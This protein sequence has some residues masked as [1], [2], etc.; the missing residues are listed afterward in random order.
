M[1]ETDSSN[2]PSLIHINTDTESSNTDTESSNTDTLSSRISIL[3][4]FESVN[5]SSDL[6]SL[7]SRISI[8]TNSDDHSALSDHSDVQSSLSRFTVHT[9][10]S[11]TS[12]ST[13]EE[14]YH[15]PTGEDSESVSLLHLSSMSSPSISE[16]DLFR[17]A[18]RAGPHYESSEEESCSHNSSEP[19]VCTICLGSD[20]D[21]FI[22]TVCGHTFHYYCLRRACF[23]QERCPNCRQNF[24]DY[25][26]HRHNLSVFMTGQTFWV[27]F[28]LSFG[29]MPHIG[30]LVPHQQRMRNWEIDGV[31][32]I[33]R[34][35][36][37][38]SRAWIAEKLAEI[39]MR[40]NIP[41]TTVLTVADLQYCEMRGIRRQVPTWDP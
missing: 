41:E 4:D 38:W 40:Y 10:T 21:R 8:L 1:S 15:V 13:D 39:R 17:E 7:G 2:S 35:T 32:N 6:R 12:R 26:L 20:R 11:V 9:S 28:E 27:Q 29:P 23:F 37:W 19:F 22:T 14:S 34:L 25:W 30:P 18:R 33:S 5:S 24:S 3:S 31:S 16:E 36:V